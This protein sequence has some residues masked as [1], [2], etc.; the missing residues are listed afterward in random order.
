[1]GAWPSQAGHVPNAAG[2]GMSFSFIFHDFCRT[3]LHHAPCFCLVL[4]LV[5][6]QKEFDLA[7]S[8]DAS[9]AEPAAE[10][11]APVTPPVTSVAVE[12]DEELVISSLLPKAAASPRKFVT[13]QMVLCDQRTR[14]LLQ[15]LV[16]TC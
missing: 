8:Q 4:R 7:S 16:E 11:A 1:M 2:Q 13:G 5:Y 3:L 9:D 6:Q 12:S 10:A 14:R 15:E